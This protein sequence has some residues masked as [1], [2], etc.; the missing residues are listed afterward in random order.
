[1]TLQSKPCASAIPLHWSSDSLKRILAFENKPSTYHRDPVSNL[2]R[3]IQS[4]SKLSFEK[5]V[6]LSSWSKAL[7]S[8]LWFFLEVLT[9]LQCYKQLQSKRFASAIPNVRKHRWIKQTDPWLCTTSPLRQARFPATTWL[10]SLRSVKRITRDELSMT[11]V[12]I[13]NTW[14]LGQWWKTPNPKSP[15]VGWSNETTVVSSNICQLPSLP[16]NIFRSS[17]GTWS[18]DQK[19]KHFEM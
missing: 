8:R 6:H 9:L 11:F 7:E 12:N 17:P 14:S 16:K 5:K 13:T 10:R 19:E 15:L 2:Q 1:M 4:H 18:R 3:Q